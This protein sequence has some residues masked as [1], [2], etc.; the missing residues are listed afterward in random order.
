[1]EYDKNKI[2]QPEWIILIYYIGSKV[3][4]DYDIWSIYYDHNEF[5]IL[6]NI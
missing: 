3:R 1:M 2:I 6:C 4:Y 5:L